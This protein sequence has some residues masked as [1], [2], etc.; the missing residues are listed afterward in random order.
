MTRFT[1]TALTTFAALLAAF[2]AAH[3]AEAMTPDT[4]A[5]GSGPQTSRVTGPSSI[6][7]LV[8]AQGEASLRKNRTDESNSAGQTVEDLPEIADYS[9]MPSELWQLRPAVQDAYARKTVN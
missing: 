8:V 1:I 4:T 3:A 2:D 9:D 6:F 7:R 5:Q